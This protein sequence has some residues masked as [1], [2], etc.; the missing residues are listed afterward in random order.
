LLFIIGSR[1]DPADGSDIGDV[2]RPLLGNED[3]EIAEIMKEIEAM[4][5][6]VKFNIQFLA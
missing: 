1:N 6:E 4:E 5:P 3:D 2:L